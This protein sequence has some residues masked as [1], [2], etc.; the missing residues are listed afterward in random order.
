LPQEATLRALLATLPLVLLAA[1]ATPREACIDAASRELRTV[2]S[3]IRETQGN[4]AR[5]YAIERGQELRVDRDWCTVELPG[6]GLAR[7]RCDETRVVETE[8]PV[9]I[10][11][12][13]EQA[14]LDGLLER[15]EGLARER[16][17][18]VR[19][20]VAAYPA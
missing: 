1:C 18:A 19:A 12:R 5:G 7:V 2:E 16:E 11:L 9:A 14:K 4:L 8:R 13:A 15:R 20:C 17:A 6:G 10:D 3:L